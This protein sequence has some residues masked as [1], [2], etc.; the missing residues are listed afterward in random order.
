[1]VIIRC[2]SL[3]LLMVLA[4]CVRVKLSALHYESI[5]NN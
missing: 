3:F 2:D 4:V 5:L 1:M